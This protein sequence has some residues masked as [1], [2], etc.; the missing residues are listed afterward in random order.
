MTIPGTDGASSGGS[1]PTLGILGRLGG[2]GARPEQIGFV[3]DGDGPDGVHAVLHAVVA[4]GE[5]DDVVVPDRR[6]PEPADAV[7]PPGVGIVVGQP[8]VL[9]VD[10]GAR[11]SPGG[12]APALLL[13]HVA[14]QAAGVGALVGPEHV[15]VAAEHVEQGQL[16]PDVDLHQTDVPLGVQL[17]VVHPGEVEEALDALRAELVAEL[18]R[19]VVARHGD[20]VG[21][22]L[23]LP[24]GQ[25]PALVHGRAQERAE[26]DD[27]ADAGGVEPGVRAELADEVPLEGGDPHGDG[28]LP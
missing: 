12:H 7:D 24:C 25:L 2:L 16:V 15:G 28:A 9:Q 8:A 22:E 27:L 26:D 17:G 20:H 11:R 13:G 10:L 3:S 19:G 6:V 5:D 1:A 21:R 14:H 4:V 18:D 23:V